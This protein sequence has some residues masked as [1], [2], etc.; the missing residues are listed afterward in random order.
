ME[1]MK[2][3]QDAELKLWFMSGSGLGAVLLAIVV[4][5]VAFRLS[6]KVTS[7]DL[8]AM[9]RA[10]KAKPLPEIKPPPKLVTNPLPDKVEG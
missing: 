5:A 7:I 8:A 9:V 10:W 6:P 1:L 2:L 4:I 3:I